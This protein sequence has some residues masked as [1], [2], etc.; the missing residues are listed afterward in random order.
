VR[1]GCS[2]WQ[3][4]HWRGDLYPQDLPASQWL[5]HYATAF[6]TVEVNACFYRV[7]SVEAARAWADRVPLGFVF[8][9]KASRFLTHNKKLKDPQAPLA[10]LMRPA[11]ALGAKLG[12]VL[13]QLPPHWRVNVERL[14]ALLELLPGDVRAA[15]EF[16]EPSWY[17]DRVMRALE[18]HG[19]ALCVHDMPGSATPRALGFV[20]GAF[21][22]AR[23]HGV[24]QAKYGGRYGG[25][26]LAPWAERFARAV[27]EG[28]DVY[29]YF[30]NDAEGAAPH[31]AMTLR[32]AIARRVVARA[33]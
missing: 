26:A 19:A 4:P 30:N 9:W 21:V 18:R 16:R 8:A 15:F 32:A 28:R 11:R 5:D 24:G 33:A 3:Y 10:V 31:D 20:G 2:G 25:R 7:P 22:Y 1:V 17:D 13:F 27:R 23:F 29:A 14:E 12:P 6:D